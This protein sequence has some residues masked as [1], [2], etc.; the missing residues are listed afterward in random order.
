MLQLRS[1]SMRPSS[2]R[3]GLRSR[4]WRERGAAAVEFALVLP[5]LLII[6]LGIIDFGIYFYNDLQLTHAAR[7]AARELSVN[8][9]AGA[10][11]AISDAAGRLVS[12]SSPNAAWPSPLPATGESFT[13]TVTATYTCITP[14]PDFIV[15]FDQQID[16]DATATMRRE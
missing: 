10:T 7:D 16:I 13:I 1:K 3:G 9:P 15:G 8:N 12:T 2:P 6:L 5:V 11:T 14:I 4:G